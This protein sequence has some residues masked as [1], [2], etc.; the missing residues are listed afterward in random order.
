MAQFE[1]ALA[2]VELWEGGWSDDPSDPGGATKYGVTWRVYKRW[3]ARDGQHV[4]NAS[5]K[6]RLKELT[7]GEAKGI[8]KKNYW[9][10]CRCDEMSGD[11]AM[12]VFDIA[13]NQG[14]GRAGKFLQRALNR[15]GSK[16]KVDGGIGPK[17]LGALLVR[18]TTRPIVRDLTVIR[19]LHYT[20]L[21]HLMGR[22]GFGWLRRAVDCAIGA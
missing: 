3:L 21:T 17:T 7:R 1:R 10:A 5:A 19:I 20:S 2:F 16:L 4:S 8:Y 14:P 12:V 18:S 22:F 15:N 11:V 9:D 13:V 6:A